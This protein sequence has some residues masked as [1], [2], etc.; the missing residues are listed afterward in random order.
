MSENLVCDKCGQRFNNRQELQKHAQ[1]CTG[2][3]AQQSGTGRPMT[4]GAG[5]QNPSR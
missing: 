2:K 4:H 3:G 1:E 5:G